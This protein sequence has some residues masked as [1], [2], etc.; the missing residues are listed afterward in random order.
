MIV[1]LVE[2]VDNATTI[3]NEENIKYNI[4]LRSVGIVF[5]NKCIWNLFVKNTCEITYFFIAIINKY[6]LKQCE[7]MNIIEFFTLLEKYKKVC[8]LFVAYNILYEPVLF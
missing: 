5:I 2:V 4:E 3:V 1:K 6:K 8:V 7:N